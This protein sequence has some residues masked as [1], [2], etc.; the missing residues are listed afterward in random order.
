MARTARP[1]AK[2]RTPTSAPGNK[3]RSPAAGFSLLE[4]MVVVLVVAIATAAVSLSMRDSSQNKLEE[5]GVRLGAL[6]ESAR[7]QSR[8]VGTD[9][10]WTP[11]TTGGFQFSG[12]PALAA[13]Q[14]PTTFLDGQTRATIVGAAQLRLGPE[15]LLAAQRVVL[16]LG[17]RS[18]AVGTD[19]LSPFQLITADDTVAA[20]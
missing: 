4:L 16:Q 19:G 9:V 5:E 7:T 3:R 15:P 11:L 13:K 20:R 17:D 10:R 12:L 18:V 14:L 6:L 2:A 8:I 1:A